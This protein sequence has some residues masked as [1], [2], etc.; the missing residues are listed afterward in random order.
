LVA[1]GPLSAAALAAAGMAR[2]E[3]NSDA[4]AEVSP[5]AYARVMNAN[6][7]GHVDR[8][9]ALDSV[10]LREAQWGERLGWVSGR[11][12]R[13][14]TGPEE[15]AAIGA[16]PMAGQDRSR[17]TGQQPRG[18]EIAREC[19]ALF[20]LTGNPAGWFDSPEPRVE[21][22][23]SAFG[24]ILARVGVIMTAPTEP[25][26]Q[27]ERGRRFGFGFVVETRRNRSDLAAHR[28]T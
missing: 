14:P 19:G 13:L 28:G 8:S 6:R 11:T 10:S 2:E 5:E 15:R 18:G 23:Q 24:S 12:L 21:N 3:G 26:N 4:A 20:A 22:A 16:T 7:I 9:L 27:G 1:G 17:P 25:L